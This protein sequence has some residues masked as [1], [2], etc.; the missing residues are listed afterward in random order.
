MW[1]RATF[2][3][4]ASRTTMSWAV[5]MTTRARPR[6][7]WR[8]P[9]AVAPA[10]PPPVSGSAVD[11]RTPHRGETCLWPTSSTP[12]GVRTH[13]TAVLPHAEMW[14]GESYGQPLA[15]RG[16]GDLVIALPA[17]RL[18]RQRRG[19]SQELSHLLGGAF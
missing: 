16:R 19:G 11:M 3:M 8:A 10:A 1:G 17:H 18:S 5:A 14:L 2:T 4:V 7:R 15:G 6:W 13:R 12:E 9:T